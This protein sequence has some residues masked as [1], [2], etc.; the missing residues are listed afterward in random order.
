[1]P[2]HSKENHRQAKKQ[3]L[4]WDKIFANEKAQKELTSKIYKQF[5]HLSIKR[6]LDIAHYYRNQIKT[7]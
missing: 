5:M 6:V 4:E 3:P 2:L 1:M 7:T